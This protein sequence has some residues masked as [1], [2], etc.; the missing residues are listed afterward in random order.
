MAGMVSKF[1]NA[2]LKK[3]GKRNLTRSSPRSL[4]FNPNPLVHLGI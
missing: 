2:L 4:Q 1:K 3:I